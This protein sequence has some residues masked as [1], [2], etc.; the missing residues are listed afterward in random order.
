M[1][2]PDAVAVELFDNEVKQAYQKM[3]CDLEKACRIRRNVEGKTYKFRKIGKGQATQRSAPA[4]D[5]VPMNVSHSLVSV[6]LEEWEAN[7]YSDMFKQAKINF[8]EVTE[9]AQVIVGALNRRKDQTAIDALDAM[10][11]A[12]GHTVSVSEGATDSNLNLAKVLRAKAIHDRKEVDESERYA[13]AHTNQKE[14]L[15][16]EEKA[17]SADYGEKRLENG[18]IVNWLGYNWIWVG[19]RDEGGLDI[20][21]SNVRNVYFCH[22]MAL[23]MALGIDVQSTVDWVSHKKSYLVSGEFLG[24][25]VVIDNLGIVKVFCDEDA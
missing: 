4:Q 23:G 16:A 15:L 9:L 20:D 12:T 11:P 2:A 1:T 25:S 14:A 24:N 17:T 10:S 8:D 7:D 19:D 18:Q 13:I 5:A 21:G 22:K 3:E 6:T